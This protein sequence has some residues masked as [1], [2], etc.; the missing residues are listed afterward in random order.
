VGVKDLE[1][2][3]IL[4]LPVDMQR[5]ILGSLSFGEA[6]KL[7]CTSKDILTLY[8]ERVTERDAVVAAGLESQFTAEFREGLSS[9][10]TALPRD[11]VVDPQVGGP[12][13]S[14]TPNCFGLLCK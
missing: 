9:A 12:R 3:S 8:E 10:Q 1:E 14:F 7:A 5:V 4:D 6:A 2:P 11:L 13:V